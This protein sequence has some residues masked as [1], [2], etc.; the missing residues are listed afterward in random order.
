MARGEGNEGAS[1]GQGPIDPGHRTIER[2]AGNEQKA[3]GIGFVESVSRASRMAKGFV[4]DGDTL[5]LA[6]GTGSVD[7]VG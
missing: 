4:S 2:K 7:D 6:R 5:G 1:G 3:L